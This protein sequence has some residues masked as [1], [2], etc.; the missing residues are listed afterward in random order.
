MT[1]VF[2]VLILSLQFSSKKLTNP[3]VTQNPPHLL[4]A[5][6][7]NTRPPPL[8]PDWT[9]A[10]V[11][12]QR[13]LHWTSGHVN[14]CEAP[15]L[16]YTMLPPS[17]RDKNTLKLAIKHEWKRREVSTARRPL[18]RHNKHA[19]EITSKSHQKNVFAGQCGRRLQPHLN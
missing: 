9:H 11:L 17:K 18:H 13:A 4:L 15:P 19:S 12:K 6:S 5:H 1:S 14:Q 7:A 3:L 16:R 10:D 2:T 8:E